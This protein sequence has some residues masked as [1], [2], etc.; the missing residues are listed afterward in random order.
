M[1][2]V[3]LIS[4]DCLSSRG[5]VAFT[6]FVIGIILLKHILL[7]AL[8]SSLEE[9]YFFRQLGRLNSHTDCLALQLLLDY[10][11][12]SQVS[13]HRVQPDTHTVYRQRLRTPCGTFFSF[14]LPQ[15]F[16]WWVISPV[17]VS[18]T[19]EIGGFCPALPIAV[20]P[21][22]PAL[23]WSHTNRNRYCSLL[24]TDSCTPTFPPPSV[25]QTFSPGFFGSA[26]YQLVWLLILFTQLVA[27]FY[28][29]C[30]MVLKL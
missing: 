14:I 20:A 11:Q 27:L 13:V 2:L 15:L 16:S 30:M 21:A 4:D 5:W 8:L 23:R 6:Y 22:G 10:A 7:W 25:I 3:E 17:P 29:I 19:S 28:S 26:S 24:L 18:T 12:C 9:H 1:C